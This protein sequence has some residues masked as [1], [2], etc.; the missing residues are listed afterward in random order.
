MALLPLQ[1]T[2]FSLQWGV[3]ILRLQKDREI[4]GL[5]WPVNAVVLALGIWLTTAAFTHP[6]GMTAWLLKPL[7]QGFSGGMTRMAQT[8]NNVISRLRS[9]FLKPPLFSF[10][11]G[12][13]TDILILRANLL[14]KGQG[15]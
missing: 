6:F 12:V 9:T 7:Q 4:R 13:E 11:A 5:A 14:P 15:Y 3:G 10:T 2:L 8:V 1:L